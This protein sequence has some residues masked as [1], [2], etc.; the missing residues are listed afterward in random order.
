M[1]ACTTDVMKFMSAATY[2]NAL[3]HDTTTD[4]KYLLLCTIN[5]IYIQLRHKHNTVVGGGKMPKSI[6]LQA[7]E[8]NAH[9]KHST[10]GTYQNK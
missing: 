2:L 5:T 8:F 7:Q 9:N 3:A 1:T 10:L 4:D 6:I